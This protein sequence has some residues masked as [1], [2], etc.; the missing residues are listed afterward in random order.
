M[1]GGSSVIIGSP[2]GLAEGGTSQKCPEPQ[3]RVDIDK[4]TI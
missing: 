4:D 2:S 1:V 3:D